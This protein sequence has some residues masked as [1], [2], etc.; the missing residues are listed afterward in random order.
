M[1][2]ILLHLQATKDL[3]EQH[4]QWH[5]HHIGVL[6][7]ITGALLVTSR[8]ASDLKECYLFPHYMNHH[9]ADSYKDDLAQQKDSKMFKFLF[10]SQ[11]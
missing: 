8:Q 10:D 6:S 11:I 4:F 2:E 5:L 3:E 1:D 9:G 7:Q